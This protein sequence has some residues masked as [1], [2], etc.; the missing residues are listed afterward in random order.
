MKYVLHDFT[1]VL[2]G[3][4]VWGVGPILSGAGSFYQRMTEL[5]W[6][7]IYRVRCG[8]FALTITQMY[9]SCFLQLD[10]A[11]MVHFRG[12][13]F[14]ASRSKWTISSWVNWLWQWRSEDAST[15]PLYVLSMF[16]LVAPT[17]CLRVAGHLGAIH[18]GVGRMLPGCIDVDKHL[19]CRSRFCHVVSAA[20]LL[21]LVRA[22]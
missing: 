5:Q 18:D 11:T 16:S 21:P 3:H 10:V 8:P 6:K 14:H 22:L 17:R 9:I 12:H 15:S 1:T 20:T 19:P 13:D 2:S 7:D 4:C